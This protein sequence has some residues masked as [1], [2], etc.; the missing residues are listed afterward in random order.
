M[1]ER[2]RRDRLY[3][4][5]LSAFLSFLE[6][7]LVFP[8]HLLSGFFVFPQ[9]G[10]L[11]ACR[12]GEKQGERERERRGGL[13]KQTVVMRTAAAG[14]PTPWFRCACANGG[15]GSPAESGVE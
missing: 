6:I 2:T 13:F 3:F 9:S 14:L 12:N 15:R 10:V 5:F 8:R 4:F 11:W 1:N 7:M